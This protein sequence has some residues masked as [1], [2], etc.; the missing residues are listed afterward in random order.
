[1]AKLPRGVTVTNQRVEDGHVVFDVTLSPWRKRW[2][3]AK[4]LRNVSVRI[5][6]PS[7]DRPTTQSDD[8]GAAGA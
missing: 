1:M 7:A 4:A 8:R 2:E 6:R 5:C 3:M